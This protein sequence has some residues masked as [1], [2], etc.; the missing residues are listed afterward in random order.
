MP[1]IHLE[2]STGLGS[3][4]YTL[5]TPSDSNAETI[6]EG[7]STLVLIH[8]I[9]C[10]SEIF[11]RNEEVH[12]AIYADPRLRRFNLLTLDLRGHGST[13]ASVDDT[14]SRETAARDVLH[15]M[16]ALNISAAHLMGV[17]MGSCIA[18]QMA[19]FAPERV[20]SLFMFSPLPLIEPPEVI[21]GRQ[22]IWD[23]WME[24]F[25]D[26]ENV[27]R[28]AL[29]DSLTGGLQYACNNRMTN[30]SRAL[31]AKVIPDSIRNWAP[32]HYDV[33]HAVTVKFFSNRPPHPAVSLARIECPVALVH[34]SEDI[35][36]PIH[37]AKELLALMQSA[38]LN[39]QFLTIDEAPHY[40]IITHS[41][42]TNQLLYEF[43]LASNN[44]AL[45]P[46]PVSVQSP[47]LADL[48]RL[49]LQEGGGG[50]SF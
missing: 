19:I 2:T 12:A 39:P 28:M 26:P 33:F 46:V 49:G 20:L 40:G 4:R 16:D 6:A 37:H 32:E 36:Y 43:L 21:G 47:F 14:Y 45:P 8:P 42:E 17:S 3:F 18:L 38:G 9:S 13:N 29:V 25:S 11:H 5:S 44:M 48:L 23:C 1:L 10:A 7:T 30:L 31:V 50:E 24:A 22:E 35:A 34:C 15:L 27:D 41:E